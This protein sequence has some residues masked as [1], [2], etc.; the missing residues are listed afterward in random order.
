MVFARPEDQFI[1][2]INENKHSETLEICP[3]STKN[4]QKPQL[5]EV[6]QNAGLHIDVIPSK[7]A[8]NF[9]ETGNA[10]IYIS[11]ELIRERLKKI[12]NNI[13]WNKP[14]AI[15]QSCFKN[16]SSLAIVF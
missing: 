16:A 7:I 4:P 14:L 1:V 12:C 5:L 3:I 13:V 6:L 9:K 11:P 15:N 10:L 2:Y 8:D